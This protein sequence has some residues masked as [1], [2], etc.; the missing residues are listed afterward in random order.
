MAATKFIVHEKLTTH[1]V[2]GAKQGDKLSS[3]VLEIATNHSTYINGW[4]HRH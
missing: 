2:P 3:E 4:S 1:K